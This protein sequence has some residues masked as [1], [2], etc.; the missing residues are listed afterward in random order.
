MKII[1]LWASP[2]NI[3][4]AFM[5]S[6]AQRKDT[7]VFDEPYYGYYLKNTLS[8]HPGKEEILKKME[9]NPKKI[10]SNILYNSQTKKNVFLKN[11]AHHINGLNISFTTQFKNVFLTRE[12]K[13]MISSFVKKI[14]DITLEDTGYK[15]QFNLLKSLLKLGENPVVIDSKKLLLN[16]RKTLMNLCDYL[17]IPFCYSMLKWGKGGIKEDGIW[18]KYWYKNVHNSTGFLPYENK[19]INIP[20]KKYSSILNECQYYYEE[21]LKHSL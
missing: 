6:F 12:P 5:Y 8:T 1:S 9:T 7:R 4:T 2:R 14:P 18:K 15:N 21:L 20:L 3:S 17:N 16:P 19:K 13:K 11:M 10:L